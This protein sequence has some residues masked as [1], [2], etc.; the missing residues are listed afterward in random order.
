MRKLKDQSSDCAFTAYNYHILK[1]KIIMFS[2]FKA[3]PTKKL[4]KDYEAKLASAM[5]AQRSGDIRT[6]SML[7]REAEEIYAQIQAHET[8]K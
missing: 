3:D 5:Q 8:A 7:T 1:E 2:I 6:Y 4:R